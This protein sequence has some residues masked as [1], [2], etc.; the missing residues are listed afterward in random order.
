MQEPKH[1]YIPGNE[2]FIGTIHS[3]TTGSSWDVWLQGGGFEYRLVGW[4]GAER[5]RQAA[6][7]GTLIC[8]LWEQVQALLAKYRDPSVSPNAA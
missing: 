6:S 8:S 7:Q 2:S 1:P 5:I 3:R 4:A